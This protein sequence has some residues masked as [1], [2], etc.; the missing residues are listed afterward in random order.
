MFKA[1]YVSIVG[2]P[3]AGKSTL[4]NAFVGEKVAIVTDKP[5]TTRNNILGIVTSENYQVVLI[6]TPGIHPSKNHLDKFMMKNVRSALAGVDLIVYLIDGTKFF[7]DDERSYVEK[8]KKGATPVIVVLTK[9]DKK[10][11]SEA[12]F[13]LKI[14]SIKNENLNL[15]MEKI[16]SYLPSYPQKTLLYDEDYYTDKPTKFLVKENIREQV[17]KNLNKEIPHGVAVEIIRFLE[18]ENIIHIDADIICERTTHKGMIIGKGGSMLKKIGKNSR[19]E[20]EL[21]LGKKVCLKIF[22]KVEEGWR[23]KPSQIGQLC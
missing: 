3:N 9:C 12:E 14:S 6:D 20:C 1:G 4:T 5:Q 15:L 11:K 21:L 2:K 7:D 10:V 13:D 19:E 16:L 22:V 23:D 8:L 17:L 18:E